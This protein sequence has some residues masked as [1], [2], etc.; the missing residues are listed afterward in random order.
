MSLGG[1]TL[2]PAHWSAV[3]A[4]VAQRLY[5]QPELLPLALPPLALS[6]VD[7][8]VKRVDREGRWQSAGRP[9]LPVAASPPSP[10]IDGVLLAQVSHTH[11]TPLGPSLVG[12][13]AWRRIGL[14]ELLAE[15]GFNLE[16]AVGSLA[17]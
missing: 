11:T 9:G 4:A 1:A 12:W 7:A 15:L 13:E 10:S 14:P 6:Q 3:A 17:K 8:I 16:K 2:A 5:G